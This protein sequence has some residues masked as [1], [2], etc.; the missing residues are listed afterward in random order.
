MKTQKNTPWHTKY[1]NRMAFAFGSLTL[2]FVITVGIY[3][4]QKASA[5]ITEERGEEFLSL[6]KNLAN[7]LATNINEREREMLLLSQRPLIK[8]FIQNT[9]TIRL[10]LERVKNSY[11]HYKWIGVADKSGIIRAA[12]DGLL[13]DEDMS[14][15]LWFLE[16]H[17]NSYLGD[18]HDDIL[19]SKKI[20]RSPNLPPFRFVDY[21]APVY[22]DTGH[23][24]GVIS[25]H[26]S[27]D[28]VAELINEF[29]PSDNRHKNTEV[30]IINSEGQILHPVSHLDG[31]HT[32]NK[33]REINGYV[34]DDW[35]S[36]DQFLIAVAKIQTDT[37]MDLG[38]RIIMRQPISTALAPIHNL[39][40][41]FYFYSILATLFAW[42][43]AYLLSGS[44][45][46]P[47]H[48]LIELS[49]N[50]EQGNENTDIRV[51]STLE[52]IKLLSTALSDMT[53]TLIA[54]KEE[55]D[56]INRH[57]E[58]KVLERTKEHAA[59]RE[60]AEKA[61]VTDGLTGLFN[62]LK[63]D[64]VLSHEIHKS[65]NYDTSLSIIFF[66]V[67]HFKSVNDTYGHPIGD[68]VLKQI[69]VILRENIRSI[70]IAGRFGGEEFLIICP[71]TDL[72]G[73]RNLAEKL[74]IAIEN[75]D[76]PTV[77]MKTASFGVVELLPNEA[78][79]SL[80]SRVDDVLYRAK[81]MGRNRVAF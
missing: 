65:I 55:V 30:F 11:S 69:S 42:L 51:D 19:L 32:F 2:F 16:S 77:G 21:A 60:T 4:E 71:Q 73:A 24:V 25:S 49:K 8:S 37:F 36:N 61:A 80:L 76:F 70:D 52:E 39:Q 67:D 40:K 53:R 7:M 78:Q 29:I 6:T 12:T 50:I 58:S 13:E 26:A 72:S 34:I 79:T 43:I 1:R 41:T 64:N 20:T 48:R 57:L 23:F 47:I 38:W 17:N 27:W 63:M 74:R 68:I 5:L 66:D 54:R 81:K 28:W 75:H 46:K 62:R 56:N 35:G 18:V 10:E 3:L 59:A 45:V 15:R 22:N 14:K 9:D 44:F 31:S 33:F